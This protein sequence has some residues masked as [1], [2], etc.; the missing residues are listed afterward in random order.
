MNKVNIKRVYEPFEKEDG[1]RILVDR[2]W[3]RGISKEKAKADS[4]LK[5]IAPS[6]E[7]RKWFNHEPEKW[8]DFVIKYKKELKNCAAV[9][10]LEEL[11]KAHKNITLLFAARDT[12]HNNAVVLKDFIEKKG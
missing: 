5:E 6:N 2:L 9:N 7:L 8:K 11:V 3:P 12:L 1:F 4:W 10:E